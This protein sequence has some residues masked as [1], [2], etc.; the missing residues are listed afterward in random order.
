MRRFILAGAIAAMTAMPAV[1]DE[2]RIE[3]VEVIFDLSAIESQ[4]A[5]TF[6]A[7]LEGDLETAII[8][9][10]ADRT[11]DEGSDVKIDIDE[12]SMSNS[13]QAALGKDS[14]IKAD[15]QV[16]NDSDSTK[17]SFYELT[18]RLDEAGDFGVG[19]NGVVEVRTIPT[20]VAYDAMIETFA[21]RVVEKLR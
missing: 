2:T 12:F 14:L 18:A 21:D 13:F 3:S 6:W 11:A 4:A 5:A 20:E 15:V 8:E 9:R 19:E 16:T 7:D 17:N 1:A 10:I